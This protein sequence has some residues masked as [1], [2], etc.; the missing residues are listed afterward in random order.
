MF[1]DGDTATQRI[2][3]SNNTALFVTVNI[4][5]ITDSMQYGANYIRKVAIKN[6]AGTTSLIGTVSTIGTDV[7]DIAGW[8]V[9]ITADNTNDSLKIEVKGA[10]EDIRWTAHIE[11][12][13]I[14]VPIAQ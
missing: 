7:E 10:G 1:L 2:T 11:G 9:Q 4:G 14:A 3:L 12:V 5:G 6:A 13:E 8:D